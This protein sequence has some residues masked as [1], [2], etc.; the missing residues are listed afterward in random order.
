MSDKTPPGPADWDPAP[1][2]QAV[3]RIREHI[4]TDEALTPE[5]REQLLRHVD[6]LEREALHP[7]R[8]PHRLR[9]HVGALGSAAEGQQGGIVE[10]LGPDR[11]AALT[12]LLPHV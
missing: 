10:V 3:E 7:E 11:I 6:A 9:A 5:D 8:S 12:G 1:T 4:L 2:L